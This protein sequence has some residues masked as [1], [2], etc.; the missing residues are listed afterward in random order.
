MSN[1]K[2]M[3][4]DILKNV[5]GAENVRD[6]FHC[7]TRLRFTLKNGVE[8]VEALKAVDGLINVLGEGK[9]IQVVV[10]QSVDN[11]Y[12]ELIQMLPEGVGTG[13]VDDPQAEASDTASKRTIDKVFNIISGIFAPYLPLLMASGIVSGLLTLASNQGWINTAGGTYAI[14]SAASNALFYFFPILL[15]FTA[16]KQFKCNP[17]IAV[18]IGASLIHPTFEALSAAEGPLNYFG[19]P[20][21]MGSYASSVLPAIAAVACYSYVEKW[22]RK[23]VPA[24]VQNLV[25]T[26]AAMAVVLPLTI[27]VF[28]P[29]G[30]TISSVIA[31]GIEKLINMSPVL[32]GIVGGGLCGYMAVFGLQWGLIP[33]IIMNVANLGYDLFV[34]MWIMANYSQVGLALGVFLKARKDP[35]LRQLS[36]SGALTGLFTGITEPIIYGLLTRFKK[37]HIPFIIGG[38]VGGAICGIFRVKAYAFMFAGILSFPGFFG[39]TFVWYLVA[40][41]AAILVACGLTLVLGYEDK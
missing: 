32:A 14:L 13:E 2:Q 26:L 28:G 19:I 9:N 23:V 3:A 7:A 37:L 10:G 35:Q 15:T 36:L 4:E 21:V 12:D 34:P 16:S 38:A 18:V 25:I 41:S 1:Y 20:F 27:M 31:S 39:D 24:S 30:N 8:D 5:G 22:L 29:V 6:V 11:V 17:Y 40:L 33:I